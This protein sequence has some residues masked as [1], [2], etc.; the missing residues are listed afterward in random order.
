MQFYRKQIMPKSKNDWQTFKLSVYN[1]LC[2]TPIYYCTTV[3]HITP[4]KICSHTNRQARHFAVVGRVAANPNSWP[5]CAAQALE[6][7]AISFL[8]FSN[9]I[10]R[11]AQ[12]ARYSQS[13]CKH[14]PLD[15]VN[16]LRMNTSV[17]AHYIRSR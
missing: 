9:T 15:N 10:N 14:M 11:A 3:R 4:L 7:V 13:N 16:V 1:T 6:S 12:R 5:Q 17:N 8:V 2:T